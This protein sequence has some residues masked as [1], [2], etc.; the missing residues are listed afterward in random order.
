MQVKSCSK[1]HLG[2]FK[3]RKNTK[4]VVS[5]DFYSKND[6]FRDFRLKEIPL[7]NLLEARKSPLSKIVKIH[8]KSLKI[9]F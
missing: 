7:G 8:Q 9:D 2:T 6:G 4:G 5:G 1:S 3:N